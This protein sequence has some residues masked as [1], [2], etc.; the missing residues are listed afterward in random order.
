MAFNLDKPKNLSYGKKINISPGDIWN[1]GCQKSHTPEF[2][3]W[4]PDLTSVCDV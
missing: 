3:P 1:K 4:N 2:L